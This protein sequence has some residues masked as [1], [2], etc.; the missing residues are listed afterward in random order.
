MKVGFLVGI[1]GF[2]V[3]ITVILK[4]FVIV[5]WVVLA[6]KG[7]PIAFATRILNAPERNYYI[8]ERECLAVIW[9]LSKFRCFFTELA[10]KFVRDHSVFGVLIVSRI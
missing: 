1:G 10:V 7:R 6:Q 5:I 8:S 3:E 4:L 9:P 2:C